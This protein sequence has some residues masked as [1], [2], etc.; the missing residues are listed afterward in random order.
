MRIKKIRLKGFRGFKDEQEI[1]MDSNLIVVYGLNG[2]GK[3]SL[4]EAVEWLFF[5]DIA[6][7]KLSSCKGEYQHDEYLKNLFYSGTEKPFVEITGIAGGKQVLIR[8]E[9]L[10]EKEFKYIVD[11]VEVKDFS[12][13]PMSLAS[14]SRPMLAQTEISC[15]VNTEQK[16]RWE[17]LSYI[18]GLEELSNLRN[19]LIDLNSNKRDTQYKDKEKEFEGLLLNIKKNTSMSALYD[20]FESFDKDA[21]YKYIVQESGESFIGSQKISCEEIIKRKLEIIFG[22]DLS[23]QVLK[24]S[25]SSSILKELIL[26]FEKDFSNLE[27]NAKNIDQGDTNFEKISFLGQGRKI[28]MPPV[29]PMCGQDTLVNERLSLIDAEIKKAEKFEIGKK[30]YDKSVVDIKDKINSVYIKEAIV[31]CL[32]SAIQLRQVAQKLIDLSLNDFAKEVQSYAGDIEIFQKKHAAELSV[33]MTSMIDNLGQF[34][35]ESSKTIQFDELKT[36]FYETTN[37]ILEGVDGCITRWT[38]LREKVVKLFGGSSSS[39]DE[40]SKWL[41]IEKLYAFIMNEQIFIKKKMLL[42]R[43]EIIRAKIESFEKEKVK[44]LLIA[45]SSEIKDYYSK[46]N[47]SEQISFKEIYVKPGKMRHAKLVAEAYGKEINP[48]TIFSEAHTNSLSLSIYFPQRVDRNPTWEFIMLDDP[49]QSMDKQHSLSLI[50]MLAETKNRKQVIVLSHAKEFVDDLL[51]RFAPYE[52][53]NYEFTHGGE[54][55]PMITLKKGKTLD[56]LLL[57]QKN[58]NGN[59]MERK[60]AGNAI[61]NAIASFSGEFLLRKGTTMAEVRRIEQ[62]GGFPKFFELLEKNGVERDDVSKINCL[63]KQAHSDS[64]SWTVRDTTPAGLAGAKQVVEDMYK[65]YIS[66]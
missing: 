63:L 12:S 16:D 65:K 31:S 3:S 2:T 33:F 7:R 42:E 6:R 25:H 58:Y 15:L 52:V 20:K 30:D 32:P 27:N 61:R 24:L 17:Q 46:L 51:S 22:S 21:I 45:H 64:H 37:K 34:Y 8:K 26:N 50:N 66:S 56:Y 39:A 60:S 5:D 44:S 28:A 41:L 18:L 1:N 57:A 38:D 29:C 49:V 14:F 35:F 40:A 36:L 59:E 62:G 53:L 55:G 47:P 23:K 4:T 11:G 48:V 13:L 10:S 19:H 43:V 9:L 54:K